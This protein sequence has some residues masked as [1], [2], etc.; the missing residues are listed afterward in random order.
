MYLRRLKDVTKKVISFAMLLRGLLDVSLNGDLI[1]ISKRRLMPAG[2]FQIIYTT[3]YSK[4]CS[5]SLLYAHQRRIQNPA[6][7]LRLFFENN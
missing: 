4:T 5:I 2:L 1:E 6:K 7:H 3:M